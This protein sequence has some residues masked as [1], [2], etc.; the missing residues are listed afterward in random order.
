MRFL[1]KGVGVVDM[2]L[3]WRELVALGKIQTICTIKSP[4]T[5]KLIPIRYGL[6]VSPEENK[7]IV[8]FS[9]H[10][11]SDQHLEFIQPLPKA[12]N[13]QLDHDIPLSMRPVLDYRTLY[14]TLDPGIVK[15]E[16]NEPQYLI[17]RA[18]IEPE[19]SLCTGANT[20]LQREPLATLTPMGN[21]R[22]W[23][24][25]WN[26]AP[27]D[28]RGHFLL[29]PDVQE[30]SN[31]RSQ[32]LS[33]AD[34]EDL[35]D[36]M[37]HS[38]PSSRGELGFIGYNSIGAG[39][40]QNHIHCHSYYSSSPLLSTSGPQKDPFFEGPGNVTMSTR[41]KLHGSDCQCSCVHINFQIAKM[42][43]IPVVAK[44]VFSFLEHLWSESVPFNLVIG[45]GS[46]YVFLRR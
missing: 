46:I 42:S 11:E 35:I 5:G 37:H 19:C 14:T 13:F 4:S 27:Q 32:A 31:R 17:P 28:P 22:P 30:P 25:H 34:I 10:H 7:E 44:E 3:R 15:I 24:F 29:V 2:G 1:G 40:S 45:K 43:D 12:R 26:I 9:V 36:L 18:H 20:L 41:I 16:P 39:A 23:Q 33:E 21:N 8:P 38:I 6:R